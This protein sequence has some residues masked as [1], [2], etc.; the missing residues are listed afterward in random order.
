MPGETV[1]RSR[2]LNL[3]F[4][5]ALVDTAYRGALLSDLRRT[6]LEAGVTEAEIVPLERYAPRTLE[7]LARALE[8][9]HAATFGVP[10]R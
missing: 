9:A 8:Q 6:L 5:R 2:A 3:V 7:G 4:N 1:L 10:E